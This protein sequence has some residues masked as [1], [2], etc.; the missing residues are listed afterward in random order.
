MARDQLAALFK[1]YDEYLSYGDTPHDYIYFPTPIVALN[2][3]FGNIKGVRS[4]AIMQVIGEPGRGKT[5]FSLELVANA[6][7]LGILEDI[8]LPNGRIINAAFADFER[9]FDSEYAAALGVDVNKVL[10]V[11]S[12]YAEQTF[13]VLLA[14]Y[15]AGLK[16]AIVDSIA[17]I[18][19]KS[20][21]GK[22][23]AH[24]NA[25]VAGEAAALQRFMKLAVQHVYDANGLLILINQFRANMSQMGNAP[26]KKAYGARSIQYAM[27]VSVDLTR[28]S[29]EKDRM[30]IKAFVEKTKQGATGKVVEFDIIHG[31]G[32]D[33]AGHVIELAVE[34]EIVEKSG[35]WYYYPNKKDATHRAQGKG[36]ANNLPINE[37]EKKLIM[38]LTNTQ[39]QEIE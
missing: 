19:P 31:A 38:L 8:K 10:I 22:S 26:D 15:E 34:N 11:R 2:K 24:D 7:R 12:D 23:I 3:A 29:R 4:G 6:Q 39:A 20:E 37:I 25:K 30:T 16:I 35:A 1:E 17:M 27:Q 13:E 9:T 18:V 33:R 21:D 32:I 36:Q 5:T 14:L 28:I